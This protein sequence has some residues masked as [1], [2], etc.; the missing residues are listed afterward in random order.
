MPVAEE[1]LSPEEKLLKV[2]QG[3]GEERA[4]K[5]DSAGP[6]PGVSSESGANARDGES[7]AVLRGGTVGSDAE[8]RT[9]TPSTA[10][11]GPI[12]AE[13][14]A[15]ERFGAGEGETTR[16]PD[17]GGKP[18]PRSER[19]LKIAPVPSKEELE[20]EEGSEIPGRKAGLKL[21]GANEGSAERGEESD[22]SGR[23]KDELSDE[24][25]DETASLTGFGSP[26]VAEKKRP[27]RELGIGTLNKCLVAIVLIM[28]GFTGFEIWANIQAAGR[29]A[30]QKSFG[31][32]W[33]GEDRSQVELP[34][35]AA[36]L[37]S[38]EDRPILREDTEIRVVPP[39]PREK[40]GDYARENLNL[41][42]LSFVAGGGGKREAI[43]VDNRDNAMSFVRVGD[44][45]LAGEIVL[46]LKE[47]HDDHV[48]LSDD[49]VE[50]IIN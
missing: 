4:V 46:E 31:D 36:L 39:E 20:F 34:P 48:V 7:V 16:A 26:G 41:I 18:V 33:I 23:E 38:F 13:T 45:I 47:I 5:G 28:L 37:K 25:A 15:R 1:N 30:V 14:G 3:D 40:G 22:G 29:E 21:T 43:I 17:K 35:V 11:M 2:I 12:H 50:V 24:Q 49:N 44:K 27:G 10:G 9:A 6:Q 8:S 19:E 32:Q 42:G